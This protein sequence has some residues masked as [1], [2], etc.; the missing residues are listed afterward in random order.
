MDCV[1]VAVIGYGHL[2]KWHAEKA[3]SLKDSNLKFI[4]EQ[5]TEVH[6]E[7][8]E[9]YPHTKI[10]SDYKDIL[11]EIDAAIVVTPTMSHFSIVRDLIEAG[12]HIFCEKPLVSTVAECAQLKK[13]ISDNSKILQVGHSERFHKVWYQKEIVER[14]FRHHEFIKIKRVAAFKGRA[15]DVDVVQDL[16][17]HDLD[18]L[19][20]LTG[21]KPSSMR[22]YGK[23]LI[24]KNWDFV[25]A[26]LDF[27]SG[28]HAQLT[29]SRI[30]TEEVRMV[31]VINKTGCLKVDLM[32]RVV[33]IFDSESKKIESFE[34]DKTDHLLEEQKQFYR[35]ILEGKES[36]IGFDDG[37][38][39]V[40]LVENVLN[41]IE[42]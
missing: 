38:K 28:K 6:N 21:E 26:E 2:G 4:V 10:V 42:S 18:L 31:E 27:E 1:N 40:A 20:F 39:A 41:S 3:E 15:T 30:H 14:F 22:A 12:I 24:T 23:K 8:K 11:R 19:M 25:S 7:I 13:L 33:S 35:S 36:V 34:Y 37:E 16:M 32:N 29:V 9:K 5:N 17:I